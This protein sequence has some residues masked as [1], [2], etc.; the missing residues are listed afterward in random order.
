MPNNRSFWAYPLLFSCFAGMT[1]A[2]GL[3]GLAQADSQQVAPSQPQ[4]RAVQPAFNA[5]QPFAAQLS[6]QIAQRPMQPKSVVHLQ[7]PKFQ[8]KS[9]VE[10]PTS[11]ATTT[12]RYQEDITQD[13]GALDLIILRQNQETQYS[14]KVSSLSRSP[15]QLTPPGA[16]QQ[17]GAQAAR[18]NVADL[19]IVL[20]GSK[21]QPG[22]YQ[23]GKGK[24]SSTNDREFIISRQL[25]SEPSHGNLGC[26]Q[27]GAG[28]FNVKQVL[29]DAN[30]NL[31]SLRATL[32]RTCERT[33]PAVAAS[34]NLPGKASSQIS[35]YTY[36]ASWS[37]Q[38][39]RLDLS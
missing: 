36:R 9:S 18:G 7:S 14:F 3:G 19:Q 20:R 16:C 24:V 33:V 22:V 10:L 13:N 31:T 32:T 15:C 30:G 5:A 35:R 2:A 28:E 12:Q 26:Q 8:F 6:D 17:G 21:L 34:S 27:W 39:K 37:A 38:F 4:I 29:Y 23:L 11:S 25:Y 1:V